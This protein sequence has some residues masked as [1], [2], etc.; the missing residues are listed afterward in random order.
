ME[1][2][3]K[4][5][6]SE[7]HREDSPKAAI[8]HPHFFPPRPT[9]AMKCCASHP[10]HCSRAGVILWNDGVNTVAVAP[11]RGGKIVTRGLTCRRGEK[12]EKHTWINR[13]SHPLPTSPLSRSGTHRGVWV[14]SCRRLMD[15]RLP[16]DALPHFRCMHALPL[17]RCIQ[18]KSGVFQTRS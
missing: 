5:C 6:L 4:D 18:Q 11:A 7:M 14:F 13:F 17:F 9:V 1:S 15:A 16:L 3:S 12:V 8:T 2:F 10:A